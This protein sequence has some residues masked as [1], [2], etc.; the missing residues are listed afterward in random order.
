VNVGRGIVRQSL[1][2]CLLDEIS[3]LA[4]LASPQFGGDGAS[5]LLGSVPAFLR[6]NGLER[7]ADFPNLGRGDMAKD[8]PVK[9]HHTAASP[10]RVN[11][12]RRS[13]QGL[14]RR[15]K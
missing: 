4:H 14:G 7:M 5:L 9:I 6:M 2:N 1:V 15:R 13:Q 8:V 11:T 10:P 12:L 3:R